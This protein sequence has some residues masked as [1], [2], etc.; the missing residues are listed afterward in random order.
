M[1]IVR[2]SK[3]MSQAFSL[4]F[5][6]EAEQEKWTIFPTLGNTMYCKLSSHFAQLSA[7]ARFMSLFD[8]VELTF[9]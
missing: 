1:T 3:S 2:L 5:I 9:P 6:T 8:Y 7:L 4:K